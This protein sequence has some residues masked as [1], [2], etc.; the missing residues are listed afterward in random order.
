MSMYPSPSNKLLMY[1]SMIT[2]AYSGLIQVCG[3]R[4]DIFF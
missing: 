2:F 4:E 1:Y 3:F